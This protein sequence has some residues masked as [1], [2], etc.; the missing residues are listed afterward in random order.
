MKILLKFGDVD[1]TKLHISSFQNSET[2]LDDKLSCVLSLFPFRQELLGTSGDVWYT[3]WH[4][5][6]L[7][8]KED[9]R[10]KLLRCFL[11]SETLV[12]MGTL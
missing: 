9:N 4:G 12:I 5:G 2:G 11:K 8:A 7:Y 1:G 6:N 3:G 10:T